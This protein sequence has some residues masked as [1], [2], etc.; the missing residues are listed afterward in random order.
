MPHRLRYYLQAPRYHRMAVTKTLYSMLFEPDGYSN[1]QAL[2]VQENPVSI[3]IPGN[4]L[5]CGG[6]CEACLRLRYG[7]LFRKPFCGWSRKPDTAARLEC[8]CRFHASSSLLIL[9]S[10][11][12][13]TLQLQQEVYILEIQATSKKDI[14]NRAGVSLRGFCVSGK[15]QNPQVTACGSCMVKKRRGNMKK[16]RYGCTHILKRKYEE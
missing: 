3:Q 10:V 15:M 11:D 8:G 9:L 7:E 14:K 5:G 1:R 6:R 13:K 4:F 12:S 16:K 2:I